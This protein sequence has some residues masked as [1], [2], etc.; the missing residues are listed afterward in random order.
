MTC[1]VPVS[2]RATLYTISAATAMPVVAEESGCVYLRAETP[3][4]EQKGDGLADE[5]RAG[6]R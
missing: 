4:R 3:A 5:P 2:C 1:K 6:R